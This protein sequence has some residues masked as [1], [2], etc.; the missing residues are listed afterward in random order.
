MN[1]NL[2]C[3]ICVDTDSQRDMT[4]SVVAEVTGG[5]ATIGGVNCAWARIAVDD[6][7]GDF[8]VRQRDPDDFLGWPT[9]LEI[10]PHDQAA[11]DEVV[12]GVTSLM[13]G[14]IDR[15]LRVLAKADYADQLPGRGEVVSPARPPQVSGEPGPP[16]GPR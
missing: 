10:M 6:D 1:D 14:L 8:E 16:R 4:A 15:G 2:F 12:R 13:N 7:Y 5:V 11:H 3:S 9:L